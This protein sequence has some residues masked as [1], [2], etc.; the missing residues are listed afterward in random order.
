MNSNFSMVKTNNKGFTLIELLVVIAIIGILASIV[1]VSLNSARQKGRDARIKG[2]LSSMR[3][4][5]EIWYDNQNPT[6]YTGFCDSGPGTS[7]DDQ[8]NF[9][10]AV[11]QSPSGA[12][13]NGSCIESASAWAAA[14]ILNSATGAS[15]KAFCVDSNG[16]SKEITVG[17]GGVAA[18]LNATAFSCN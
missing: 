18:A 4:A 15:T 16:A 10:D 6:A 3:G 12:A 1:L 2:G 5:A 11:S 8:V 13:A 17:T 7:A 14:V 9:A